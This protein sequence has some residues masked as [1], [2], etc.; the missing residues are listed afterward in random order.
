MSLNEFGIIQY[1]MNQEFTNINR[2]PTS[3][4]YQP[5]GNSSRS[6]VL[7]DFVGVFMILA[8]GILIMFLTR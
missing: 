8:A 2:C 6:L 4:N 3:V 5:K 7:T 1:L